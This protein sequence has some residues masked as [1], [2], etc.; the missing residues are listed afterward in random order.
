MLDQ[1][2]I[3][4]SSDPL[5]EVARHVSTPSVAWTKSP[6]RM[7]LCPRCCRRR[8]GGEPEADPS[9]SDPTRSHLWETVL[10]P[11]KYL[12]SC[13][14]A[15][16]TPLM[17]QFAGVCCSEAMKTIRGKMSNN[18]GGERRAVVKVGSCPNSG[19]PPHAPVTSIHG[20]AHRL[21]SRSCWRTFQRNSASSCSSHGPSSS[22]AC[23]PSLALFAGPPVRTGRLG[24]SPVKRRA[25][26]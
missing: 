24:C 6:A 10:I 18:K 7:G 20:G 21:S 13:A 1:N 9:R 5:T 14:A 17:S 11:G 23:P 22:C 26:T 16:S 2:A 25:H 4:D 12:L 3:S 8:R 19:P 15:L